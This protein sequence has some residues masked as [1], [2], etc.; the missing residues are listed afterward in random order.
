VPDL[1][2]LHEE[3]AGTITAGRHTSD[4]LDDI[5]GIGHR[6]V[7]ASEATSITLIRGERART[8]SFHGQMARDAEEMQY[9]RGYG[10]CLDA[11]RAGLVFTIADTRTDDRWP[12]YAREVSG[13]GVRS[14]LSVPL[15]FQGAT[16]GALNF[17]AT[18]ASA[19]TDADV[20]LGEEVST[21]VAIA[22]GNGEAVAR[23]AEDAENM[24]RAMSSR[25]VIEQG[26]GILMERHKLTAD[27]AF[28]VLSRIS[29]Q[30]NRKLRDIAEHLVQTGELLTG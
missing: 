19:F 29:Q 8:A 16:I 11:A 20:A 10:P 15:P 5:T 28:T 9:E 4:V 18:R 12:D 13:R 2:K 3:L 26:K 27:Q 24:R 17:Y 23:T 1:S 14:S 22:V 30:T 7:A 6:A 25:A 21:W